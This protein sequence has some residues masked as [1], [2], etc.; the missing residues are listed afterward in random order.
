MVGKTKLVELVFGAV[1]SP[2]D[3]FS[4][5]SHRTSAVSS[6]MKPLWRLEP[7]CL[8]STASEIGPYPALMR[9]HFLQMRLPGPLDGNDSLHLRQTRF[10][11]APFGFTGSSIVVYS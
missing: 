9:V 7:R 2:C 6:I 3:L 5:Y 11:V 4:P 1:N 8:A 10:F